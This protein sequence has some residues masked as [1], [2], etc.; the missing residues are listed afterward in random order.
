M[1]QESPP[2]LTSSTRIF[3]P[4]Q[5]DFALSESELHGSIL[6]LGANDGGFVTHLR[7]VLGNTSA[8]GVEVRQQQVAQNAE[9]IIIA[10]ARRLPF[11]DES[12]DTVVA[13]HYMSIFFSDDDPTIPLH[14]AL[15]VLKPGGRFVFDIGDPV[16]E[17]NS[18]DHVAKRQAGLKLFNSALDDLEAQGYGI[19]KTPR[20]LEG[21]P[22]NGEIVSIT[23][24]SATFSAEL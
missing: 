13:R 6:D 10:D 11:D 5:R 14:E 15:R 2:M 23:K 21:Q 22:L 18:T 8:Q 12:F 7:K 19:T 3:E 17:K 1:K 16:H 20:I 24:S 9:G 4:Y